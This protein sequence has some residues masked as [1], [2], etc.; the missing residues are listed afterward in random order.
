MKNLFLLLNKLTKLDYQFLLVVIGFSL[1]NNVYACS[2]VF[3]YWVFFGICLSAGT[4]IILLII[5]HRVSKE[6]AHSIRIL[7]GILLLPFI[8][9]V[10]LI[11]SM[12]L[13]QLISYGHF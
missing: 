3:F 6:A 13:I 4:A 9:L 7:A 2:L 8:L 11:G 10:L 12:F 1:T 5:S